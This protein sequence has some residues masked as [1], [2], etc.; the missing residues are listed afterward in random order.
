MLISEGLAA[1]GLTNASGRLALVALA[2]ACLLLIMRRW[3]HKTA[4]ACME[5]LAQPLSSV[6]REASLDCD[7]ETASTSSCRRL[8]GNLRLAADHVESIRTLL[9]VS[10]THQQ[11]I[12]RAAFQ[13]LQLVSK[14]LREIQR[15]LD[16]GL[17]AG[18]QKDALHRT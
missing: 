11:P 9:E 15:Q 10:Q 8:S 13:N 5:P 14:H 18:H 16:P 2:F 6:S 12:P 1:A 7:Q 17:Q 4:V 3:W